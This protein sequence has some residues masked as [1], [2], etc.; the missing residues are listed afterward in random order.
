MIYFKHLEDVKED[1]FTH[2]K[3]ALGI[4]FNMLKGSMMVLIHAFYPNFFESSG[5]D[6]C[7][8]IVFLV[9]N[10]KKK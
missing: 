9:D 8:E 6:I 7:R 4:S 2:F 1:Y 3:S 10:K 5:S